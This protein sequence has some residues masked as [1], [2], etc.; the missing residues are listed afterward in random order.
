MGGDWLA[1]SLSDELAMKIQGTEWKSLGPTYTKSQVQQQTPVTP[2]LGSAD[3]RVPG[4][5]LLNQ[6]RQMGEPEFQ[7]ETLSQKNKMA[8]H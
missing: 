3:W 8:Y 6:P 7:R 1:G 4:D 2:V 5:S